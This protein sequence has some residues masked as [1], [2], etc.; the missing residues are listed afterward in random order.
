MAFGWLQDFNVG[1]ILPAPGLQR[2]PHPAGS[3]DVQLYILTVVVGVE[4]VVDFIRGRHD[5]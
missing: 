5:V 1:R 2:R 4:H 3:L